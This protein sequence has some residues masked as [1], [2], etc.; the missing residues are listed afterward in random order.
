[1]LL[2]ILTAI[3]LIPV[4]VALVWWGPAPLLAAVAAIVALL[5]LHEFF[6]LG[7][8]VGMRAFRNWTMLCAAGLF[9]A[10]Y[11]AG[12]IEIHSLS[13]GA[14]LIRDAT[15]GAVSAEL[16]LLIF[17]FGSVSIGLATRRPLQDVLPAIAIG[18]AGLLFVALPFSYLVRVNE[19]DHF[20]R[21]LVLFT[22]CLIW[23]GDMLAYFVGRSLGRLPMAPA[24]SPKK[25]WEGAIANLL[26]SLLV[27]VL[28][29][30]WMQ[31]D[32]A[33]LLVVAALAN[34]A[35]Q[36]GD[37]IESAYKRGAVVKDSGALLPGHGGMLDRVDSLIL[38]APVVWIAWQWI[39]TR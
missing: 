24:L 11:A 20:G 21:Q 22:L 23:A 33:S 2:R 17:L 3:V 12:M 19:I 10:Q 16:V 39:A 26:A 28:F 14:L 25:T 29:A 13:G 32:I 1:M 15:R 8:R 37:L 7:E 36:M 31:A 18:S 5:A 30:R 27:A 34:I 6:T 9:Y 4:V 38:A 35:G